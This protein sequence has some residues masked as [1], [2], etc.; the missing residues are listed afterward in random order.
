MKDN[1]Q[2]LGFELGFAPDMD[3]LTP[4]VVTD[5]RNFIPTTRGMQALHAPVFVAGSVFDGPIFTT[6]RIIAYGFRA[7]SETFA[8]NAE[9]A[10]TKDALYLRMDRYSNWV[11]ITSASKLYNSGFW[12]FTNFGTVMI[13]AEGGEVLQAPSPNVPY[14]LHTLPLIST[15]PTKATPIA[16]APT[17]CIVTSAERFVLAF[18]GRGGDGDTWNCSAR[19]D[20]TSW[21]LSP[22][23]L[24]AQGRLVEPYGPITAALPM[25]N[26]VIAYKSAGAVR[27]R[28][29]PGDAEVWKWARLPVRIGAASPRAACQLPD[30]RHAV[31]NAESCWIFD[32]TQAVDVLAGKARDWFQ[33]NAANTSYQYGG[34]ATVYDGITNSVWFT[35]RQ[36][37]EVLATYALVYHLSTGKLGLVALPADL[38]VETGDIYGGYSTVRTPGYFESNTHRML[39]FGN[40]TVSGG[41]IS[42]ASAQG[43]PSYPVPV[44]ITTGDTGDPFDLIDVT[45]VKLDFVRGNDATG[46]CGVQLLSRDTRDD[47]S[48]ANGTAEIKTATHIAGGDRY[49]ARSSAHWHRARVLPGAGRM[50][51]SGVW[52][53]AATTKSERGG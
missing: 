8:Q 28:F 33:L 36:P 19:D 7:Q 24:A 52:L 17:C 2:R 51:L 4:G 11:D 42:T 47:A 9:Y 16:G 20:H 12:T 37:N 39:A 6:E 18:N 30:G 34:M 44:Y 15:G 46:T 32:G 43:G 40:V 35:F 13:G 50:D 26:D 29:V 31:M 21:T 23:T 53:R 10:A 49:A 48:I 41:T 5:C 1:R 14:A 45:G 38:I 3:P 27:G 22:A 25:G